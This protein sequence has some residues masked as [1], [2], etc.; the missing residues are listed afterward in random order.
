MPVIEVTDLSR[1][2]LEVFSGLTEAQLRNRLEPEKGIFI[3]ESEKVITLALNAGYEPVSLL[4]ERKHIE[5]NAREIIAR[6][7][8]IPVYTAS[9]ET[10]AG[11]TGFELTRGIMCA[12]RRPRPKTAEEVC[13]NARRIAVLE[14]ITDSTN[15]GAVF[16]SAA[17]LGIDGILLTPSCCDPLYRRSVRVSMGTALLIPYAV[18]GDSPEEWLSCG[19]SR[20][21]EMG[22]ATAAMALCENS[23]SLADPMLKNSDRLAVI[24]G[25]EGDGLS[26]ETIANSDY[27]VKIPM[28]RGVDSLN[29]AAAAA[30]TFWEICRADE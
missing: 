22:F 2:G 1:Q 26:R 21:K 12:M 3:A 23:V 15:I 28:A 4:M 19:I 30:V 9:R 10:L 13:R 5:G 8:D 24:F 29:V 11:L 16:R 20:L 6:C 7:G 25:T 17:A 18:I 27:R 14:N